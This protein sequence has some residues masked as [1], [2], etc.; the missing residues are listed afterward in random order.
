MCLVLFFQEFATLTKELNQ[1]REQVLEKDEE[2]TELKAERNNTRLL[3]EHLECLVSRHERSLRMTVVKRQAASQSGVSSEVEV[4]KALK[5]L[6]EHHK[7]LDEKVR[8]RL[9]IA[10]E[11]NSTLEEEL[12][13][14]RDELNKFKSGQIVV[15]SGDDGDERENVENGADDA[16]SNSD[17][18]ST[19]GTTTIKK[20]NGTLDPEVLELRRQIEKHAKDLGQSHRSLSE[21]RSQKTEMEEK[22]GQL[23]KELNSAQELIKRLEIDL[24]ENV[25]Q[26]ED[27]EERIATLEKR[28]LNSQREATMLHDLN[29]KLEQEIKNKEEQYM[30]SHDKIKAITEKLDISEQKLIEFASMPD[31]EEQLKD[32]MEALTQAQERQGTAEER[33]QRLESQLEEKSADVL[34]LTQRLKMNEEHNQRL[35]AT[36]D[37]LLSGRIFLPLLSIA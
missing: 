17:S 2:I 28:Y 3:L 10:L 12:E 8:E 5:S 14:T 22:M 11:K 7:A 30:L 6:F 24:K 4:L 32:R 20:V 34:K 21:L 35:S 25:A 13:G 27:Q 31:I 37:K 36:V 9:R 29:E 16:N 26:K 33:V 23:N 1:A 19:S 18:N 15:K